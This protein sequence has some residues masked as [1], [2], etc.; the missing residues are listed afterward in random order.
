MDIREIPVRVVG[1]GT[2]PE[3]EDGKVL[4]YIDMPSDMWKYSEPTLPAPEEVANLD[5]AHEAMRWLEDALASYPDSETSMLADLT[6]LDADNRS[7]VNQILGE[8]EVA[9]SY[10]DQVQARCQESVLAGVWRTLY[11]NDADQLTLDILEVADAPHI[12]RQPLSNVRR[13]DCDPGNAPTDVMNAMSILVELESH[14]ADFETTGTSHVINLTLL[15]LSDADQLFLDD[16]LGRGPVDTLSRAY[17][18]CQVISTEVP[19]VWW[20]RFYNSM[21]TL[22]LNTLEVVG[23]PAV[24]CAAPEDLQDSQSRLSGLLAPYWPEVA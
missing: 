16:R 22:I 18:K 1:P 17:G 20:V 14:R 4:S 2:Q 12:V 11:V 7:M 21:G 23:V 24:I 9:I 13:I 15:P 19:N 10:N 6:L 3:E 8:G 5:G